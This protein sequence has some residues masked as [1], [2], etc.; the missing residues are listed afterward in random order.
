MQGMD[1]EARGRRRARRRTDRD[2]DE[3]VKGKF[4]FRER[5]SRAVLADI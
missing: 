1:Y 2:T 3:G 4:K 5:G